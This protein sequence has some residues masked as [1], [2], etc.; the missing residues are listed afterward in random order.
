MRV[1]TSRM[2]DCSARL[3]SACSAM[4]C[5]SIRLSIPGI[6]LSLGEMRICEVL[7]TR[8]VSQ[9]FNSVGFRI[10]ELA[11]SER[12]SFGVFVL[13]PLEARPRQWTFLVQGLRYT[14]AQSLRRVVHHYS[15]VGVLLL[16]SLDLFCDLFLSRST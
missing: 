16:K 11:A 3:S 12:M 14:L 13:P 5:T 15:D 8:P 4:I 2:E 1:I 6:G 7:G 9:L 10:I